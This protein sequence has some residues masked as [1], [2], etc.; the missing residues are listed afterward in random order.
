MMEEP[1]VLTVAAGMG[2]TVTVTAAE[3]ASQPTGEVTLTLYAPAAVA[4]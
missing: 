1:E 3:V 4:V 2:L